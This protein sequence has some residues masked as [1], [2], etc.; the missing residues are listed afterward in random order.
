M[1]TSVL[2]AC[3]L[4]QGL[5]GKPAPFVDD[6]ADSALPVGV[7]ETCNGVDDDGD[8]AVDEGFADE[9]GDG[10][11]DCVEAA[12]PTLASADGATVPEVDACQGGEPEPGSFA[13][14][15]AWTLDP[16][17]AGFYRGLQ[18]GLLADTNHDG[19]VDTSD[20]ST[21][22]G[23]LYAN[24]G[25][26]IAY[27]GDGS[28]VLWTVPDTY[29]YSGTAIADVDG[30]GANEV[31]TYRQDGMIE[32]ID[33]TG[34]VEWVSD[35]AGSMLSAA[36]PVVADLDGDG[37]AEVVTPRLILDGA[38][39]VAW[40]TDL[41]CSQCLALAVADLDRDGT[42]EI[43]D[44]GTAYDLAGNV[45]WSAAPD[46]WAMPLV[47][48]ADSDDDAE[49]V[50]LGP[51]QTQV[52]DTDGTILQSW[53]AA[54][55]GLGCTADVDGDGVPEI[56]S[57]AGGALEVRTL[58]G[59]L[60][61][62]ATASDVSGG[63]GCFAYDFDGDGRQ[64]IAFTDEQW[65]QIVDGETGTQLAEAAIRSGTTFDPPFVADVDGDGE[66]ELV[67]G[68]SYGMGHGE[69]GVFV[70]DAGSGS[71]GSAPRSWPEAEYVDGMLEDDGHVPSPTPAAWLSSNGYRSRERNDVD[72]PATPD[73]VLN[74]LEHCSATCDAGPSSV[75]LQVAN[76]GAA[77]V[78]GTVTVGIYDGDAEVASVEVGPLPAGTSLASVEVVLPDGAVPAGGWTARID[79]GGAVSECDET[80]NETSWA[81]GECP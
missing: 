20:A 34:A 67:V 71:W 52:V 10:V 75:S 28:G 72:V 17:Q 46:S 48:N 41:P 11:A 77:D 61:S 21:I 69:Q 50:I 1:W 32:A 53:A 2:V 66:A 31:I 56:V 79:D 6:T 73:L 18:A 45:V 78:D 54:N 30:D 74:V 40:S 55:V 80:N 62:S 76:Q 59:T 3:A 29:T 70:F 27:S 37:A 47:L 25:E 12:C 42:D 8:G 51:S 9:D 81:V 65:F 14:S 63:L 24:T 43:I 44:G 68:G 64:E 23:N 39:G 49:V 13:L 58:D 4:D 57:S 33:G 38:T 5:E 26:L 22:V 60:V 7:E 15:L 35:E 19:G 16:G 36:T